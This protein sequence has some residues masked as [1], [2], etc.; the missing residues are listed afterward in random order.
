MKIAI[1]HSE[2]FEKFLG[3]KGK[4]AKNIP[5][6]HTLIKGEDGWYQL[7]DYD[8][9]E[10]SE[11]LDGL[12]AA[13]SS[14]ILEIEIDVPAADDD[15]EVEESPK[16]KKVA[17]KKAQAK[18]KI[19]VQKK[20][21]PKT[22]KKEP[23][24]IKSERVAVDLADPDEGDDEPK[25]FLGRTVSINV[26][27]QE[28]VVMFDDGVEVELPILDLVHIREDVKKSKK[29]FTTKEVNAMKGKTKAPEKTSAKTSAKKV[30]EKTSAKAPAKPT[31]K[32]GRPAKEVVAEKPV[33]KV[34]KAPA[35]PAKKVVKKVEEKAS[36]KTDKPV[37][38]AAKAV[39]PS[40]A[41]KAVKGK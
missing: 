28:A 37:K 13:A 18:T 30:V 25:F 34:A 41:K 32:P 22:K 35:K 3:I 40:K 2:K 9:E 16:S 36:A 5:F 20:E 15:F 39:S 31:K 7:R 26:K 14:R 29:S 38:K 19:K 11:W 6:A 21:E 33:K 27:K 23:A 17:L 1:L 10:F 12:P 8:G 4:T 24:L